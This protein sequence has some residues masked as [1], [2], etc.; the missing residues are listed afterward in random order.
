MQEA[1]NGPCMMLI[2]HIDTRHSVQ[3]RT[4][5]HYKALEPRSGARDDT[6][7]NDGVA[8]L[9]LATLAAAATAAATTCDLPQ[10]GGPYSRAPV[11]RR[12][13]ACATR[14]AYLRTCTGT[15]AAGCILRDCI[16]CECSCTHAGMQA[17]MHGVWGW[18]GKAL[19]LMK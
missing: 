7:A 3:H 8:H 11:R 15:H 17:W 6:L 2:T 19:H 12:R 18:V 4:S 5:T 9:A 10:P 14:E 13:G 16:G 1:R